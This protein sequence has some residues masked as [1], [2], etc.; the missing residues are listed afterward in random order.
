MKTLF[1]LLVIVS[2]GIRAQEN[3][4]LD[5][6]L[7][8]TENKQDASYYLISERIDTTEFL[9]GIYRMDKTLLMTGNSIDSRGIRLNGLAKWYHGNGNLE[10][11]G[12]YNNGTKTGVWKRYDKEGNA[13][14]D[15][16]TAM[17]I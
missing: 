3:I 9:V 2:S 4:W 7:N 5:T 16:V 1:L 13:R 14:P 12:Y 15:R 8:I 11:E 6:K 17:L 10:S